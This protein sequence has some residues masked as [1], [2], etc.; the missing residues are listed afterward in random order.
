M[1]EYKKYAKDFGSKEFLLN[2]TNRRW[3]LTKTTK[4]GEVMSLIRQCQPKSFVQWETWYFENAVT[5]TKQ[6]IKVSKEILTELGERLYSKL[7]ET[8]I[9]QITEAIRTLTLED[10]ID[11]IYELTIYRTYDGY[12]TEKSVVFDNLAKVFKNVVF[13]ESDPHLDHSGDIDFIGKIN[14]KA[15]GLQ[16]K[17]V[18]A[19]ANLGNYNISARM[20]N[21]FKDFQEKYGGQVFIVYSIDEKIMNMDIFDKIATEIE[22]LSEL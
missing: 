2:Y 21:S 5:N 12:L 6:P 11:Y 7:K 1:P 15:F 4:V 19:N 17:P 16:I 18:T 22:R 3:G 8:V 20:Q 9:P 14:D 13:E 10:C